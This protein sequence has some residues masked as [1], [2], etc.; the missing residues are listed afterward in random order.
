MT[1]FQHSVS[2]GLQQHW[3]ILAM[4]WPRGLLRC[5]SLANKTSTLWHEWLKSMLEVG[6]SQWLMALVP[7]YCITHS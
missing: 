1:G 3:H 4:C 5:N 2:G 7:T 6:S